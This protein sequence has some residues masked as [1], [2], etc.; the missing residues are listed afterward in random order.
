[1]RSLLPLLLLPS[2][3]VAQ[4]DV[5]LRLGVA[6]HRG[7]AV[8]P[9]EADQPHLGP[10]VS[11]QLG[12]SIG[13]RRGAWRAAAALRRA[14][15]DL[16]VGG[17]GGGIFTPGVLSSWQATL[18]LGRTVLGGIGSPTLQ[19]EGGIAATRW[20]FARFDDP[21]RWRWGGYLALEGALA[22]AGAVE[23]V[24]RTEAASSGGLFV[25]KELPEGFVRERSWQWALELGVRVRP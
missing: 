1:M 19:A 12:A 7:H 18:G 24:L 8:A 9:D 10:A 23:G 5:T 25:E 13:Y 22:L 21:P 20:S 3:L 17:S 11:R 2:P 14:T 15:P 16:R 4:F 6:E